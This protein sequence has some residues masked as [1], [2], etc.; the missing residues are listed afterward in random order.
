MVG[1]AL[2]ERW[3]SLMGSVWLG[4]AD[5]AVLG[6]ADGADVGDTLG[7]CVRAADT[8]AMRDTALVREGSHSSHAA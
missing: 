8:P 7:V 5:G 1:D 3:G 2:G 4:D 6:A